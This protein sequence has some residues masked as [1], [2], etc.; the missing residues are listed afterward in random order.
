MKLP[1]LVE[2]LIDWYRWKIITSMVIRNE[3]FENPDFY[4]MKVHIIPPELLYK[5]FGIMSTMR[6]PIVEYNTIKNENSTYRHIIQRVIRR[7]NIDTRKYKIY[8]T[9]HGYRI[10]DLDQK[11]DRLIK[12]YADAYGWHRCSLIIHKN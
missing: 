7:W 3:L 9:V 10:Y 2:E 1:I 11:I 12:L 4:M 8:V 5:S 6:N